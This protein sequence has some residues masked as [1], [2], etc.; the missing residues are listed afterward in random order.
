MDETEP[1]AGLAAVEDPRPDADPGGTAQ[2]DPERPGD[3]DAPA[4]TGEAGTEEGPHGIEAYQFPEDF[5]VDNERLSAFHGVVEQYGV[6]LEGAQALLDLFVDNQAQQNKSQRDQLVQQ[7]QTWEQ[8]VKSDKL[9]GGA[10]Y[11][12]KLAVA[13][14]AVER[15]GDQGLRDYLDATGAGSHPD[16]V[17]WMYRVGQATADDRFLPPGSGAGPLSPEARARRL[18]DKTYKD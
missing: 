9:V 5:A 15:Y 11:E 8:Q 18:Y 13:R 2:T 7:V 1:A 12:R 14:A 17:R 16:V 4:E 10:D 3:A 6:P